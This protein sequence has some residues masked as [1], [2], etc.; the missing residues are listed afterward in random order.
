MRFSIHFL[1]IVL[2]FCSCTNEPEETQQPT[3]PNIEQNKNI[4]VDS[5]EGERYVVYANSEY[6]LMVSFSTTL[7]SVELEFEEV[8]GDF[9]NILRDNNGN[10]WN[11]FGYSTS[12]PDKGRR[13]N[14]M[15]GTMG[16]F[17]SFA[18]FFPEVS[19]FSFGQGQV[20]PQEQSPDWTIDREF[21]FFGA[22]KDGIPSI[23]NPKFNPHTI[24][25]NDI[26]YLVDTDLVIVSFLRG[27]IR[28][29]PHKIL[30]WHE[31]VN[32][33][34]DG[35]L[36]VVSYCPLTG[37]GNIW[38][39]DISS[40]NSTFGVSGLLYNSNLILYD[41]ATDSRWS[42]IKQESVHGDRKGDLPVVL[43]Y[44]EMTWEGAKLLGREIDVLSLETGFQRDYDFYPYGNYKTNNEN[45]GYP[46]TYTDNRIPAKERVYS[47][48]INGRSKVYRFIDFN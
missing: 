30:D 41:R 3:S 4:L 26:D 9:P 11:I 12:G 44:Y 18:A 13:L 21:V 19:S 39:R 28:V 42:Q 5:F 15:N 14:Q 47:I 38:E 24:A 48:L 45:I 22:S 20:I 31:I 10:V 27:Q 17:F 33:T 8:V 46:L 25:K 2:S 40:V 36:T 29:Y 35:M 6:G 34:H 16:F 32:E 7:D 1:L 43:P 37:T 23:D